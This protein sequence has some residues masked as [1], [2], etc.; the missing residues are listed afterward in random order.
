GDVLERLLH[1]RHEAR[2]ETAVFVLAD[3][4]ADEHHFAARAN[5]VGETFRLRPAGGLQHGVGRWN[6]GHS[7][8]PPPR[9]C[10]AGPGNPSPARKVLRR[11]WTP[12]TRVYPSSGA[13]S[14]QVG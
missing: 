8:F 14:T 7:R 4:A 10:R 11:R 13:L 6:F 5:A 3:H 2:G 12:R 1:L 9:Q